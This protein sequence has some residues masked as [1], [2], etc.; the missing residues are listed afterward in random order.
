VLP[1]LGCAV[2]VL[3]P[4]GYLVVRSLGADAGQVGAVIFR[5]QSLVQLSNTL[6]LCAAVVL[7]TTLTALPAAWLTSR[8]DLPMKRFFALV[9]VLPLAIPGYLMAYAL[10]SLGG[11][12]GAAFHLTGV[13]VPRLRGFTGSLVALSV[14]NFPYMLLN[15]RAGLSSYDTSLE[16]VARSLGHRPMRVFFTVV[17]PQL[18][19]AILAGGLLVSLHVVSDFGVVSLM[20]YETFSYALYQAYQGAYG[21]RGAAPIALI[22]MA[23]AGVFILSEMM[24]LRRV[25]LTRAGAGPARVR[26]PLRLRRWVGPSLV[27]IGMLLL[28]GL[29][30]P[31]FT[32]VY[33]AWGVEVGSQWRSLRGAV[34]DSLSVSGPSALVAT[35]LALPIAYMARRYPSRWTA[36]LERL[37]FLGYATPPLAFALGLLVVTLGVVPGL[38]QTVFV[39]VYAYSLHFLAEAVGPIRAGLFSADPRLEEASRALG[40]GPVWTFVRVTLPLLR[41]GL[42]VSLSLVFLSVMKELPLTMLLAPPGFETLSMNI[43]QYTEE[44]MY[45][46]AAPYA[47]VVLG[48]SGLLVGVLV[49]NERGMR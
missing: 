28:V 4:L 19:P 13:S 23:L 8:T 25:V 42:I 17:L 11:D 20:R 10:L 6:T 44:A 34:V 37:G 18:R 48:V 40:Y 21:T 2:A 32:I 30:L 39:L 26:R 15:L 24:L 7:V 43:W 33:G 36:G 1:A 9:L 5:R 31:V 38:Y 47:L 29:V 35:A 22:M 49:Y 27:F 3:L 12:Y 14:Y 46:S 45:A 41:P 16:E